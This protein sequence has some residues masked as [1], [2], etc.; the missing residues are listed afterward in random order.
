MTAK[1]GTTVKRGN[2]S[3]PPSRHGRELQAVVSRSQHEA[4]QMLAAADRIAR[5]DLG[6]P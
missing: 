1:R 4:Q 3:G 5:E 2:P 6:W